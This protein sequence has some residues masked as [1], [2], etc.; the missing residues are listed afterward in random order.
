MGF[1]DVFWL[2]FIWIPLVMVWMF[3][4]SDIFARR[5]IAGWAKAGWLLSVIILP[6]LGT[7]I[8]LAVRPQDAYVTRSVPNLSAVEAYDPVGDLETLSRLR[9][10]GKLTEEEFV[11]AKSKVL[12]A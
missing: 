6:V 12:A 2:L 5:D 11:T 10:A 7:L 9:Q 4:V 8:Y 3:S 1:W